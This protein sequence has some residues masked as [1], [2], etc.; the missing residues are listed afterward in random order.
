MKSPV[1]GAWGARLG[2]SPRR[3]TLADRDDL[4]VQ[5]RTVLI[6]DD[7]AAF[8]RFARRLLEAEG[9]TVIGEAGDGAGAVAKARALRP[10]VVLLDVLLPDLDG[11]AVADL[12]AHE[13]DRPQVVLT[14]SRDEGDFGRRLATTS[15][16]GFVSKRDLSGT[17][18]EALLGVA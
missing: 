6:V 14:S 9:F 16:C 11:F 3:A 4:R 1:C 13:P 15:A 10:A 2:I 5:S 7:H 12:L 8:R 18:L 17:R